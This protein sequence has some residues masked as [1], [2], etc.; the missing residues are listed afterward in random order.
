MIGEGEIAFEIILC[1]MQNPQPGGWWLMK[2]N[3]KNVVQTG[4]E[5]DDY[6]KA[7]RADPKLRPLENEFLDLLSKDLRLGAR[8]LDLGSGTGLPYDKYLADRG[9]H[10]TGVDF[11]QKHLALA[12]NNVPQAEYMEGDFSK[13]GFPS[14][15]FDAVVSFYAIFHLPR[16][17]HQ[18]LFRNIHRWLKPHGVM[19]ATL[20][21]SDMECDEEADWLGAPMMWSS[22]P[23]EEYLRIMDQTGFAVRKSGFE[24]APG[25]Q[26]YHFWL[27]AEKT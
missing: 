13:L 22:Y 1:I 4:Y 3:M 24:G 20:G 17:E 8:V 14:E 19:L 2:K 6:E 26:E 16:E 25:D 9:F 18:S 23:P 15:A 11:S 27:L 12:R 21:T 7:F 10:I 5:A